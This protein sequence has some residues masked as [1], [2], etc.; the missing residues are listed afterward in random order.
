[1]ASYLF[2]GLWNPPLILLLWISTMVDWMAGNKL[3]REERQKVRKLWLLLSLF[4]NLGFLA[5][6]KY[7]NFLL[8]NF[9]WLA[10]IAGITFQARPLDIIL[11]MGISFYTF[12]TMSYTIDMYYKKIQP[13]R[14]FLDFAL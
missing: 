4:V 3:F 13:A 5:F 8:E 9:I 2:Y 14:T 10:G 6:F 12:Q 7:N 11:P 1:M